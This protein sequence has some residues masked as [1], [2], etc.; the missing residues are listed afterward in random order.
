MWRCSVLLLLMIGWALPSEL[1][2]Q[3][4]A[5]E[6]VVRRAET[7][8]ALSGIQISL[9]GTGRGAISTAVGRFVLRDL[10]PGRYTVVANA[11]GYATERR[12]VRVETGQTLQLAVELAQRA[13]EVGGIT[14]IGQR[15]G[16]VADE[17]VTSKIPAPLIE[18]PQAISVVTRERLEIRNANSLAEAARYAPGIQAEPFGVEPRFTWL[19]LRGFDATTTGLYRDGLQLRNP[20]YAVSFNLEPYGAEQIEVLR[21]PASVLYG[22]GS[23]GGLVN[24]VTKRPSAVP[25]REVE[26]EIGSNERLQGQ[27]DLGGPVN[28]A[29]T[30]SYRLTGLLRDSETQVE[31]VGDDRVF[32]APAFGWRPGGATTLTLLG[33]YQ[34]DETRASQA[35][36]AEG[37][38]TENPFGEVPLD[39]FTGEPDVDRYEATTFSA[40]YLFEHDATDALSLRQKLRFYGAELDDVTVFASA[41]QP[42]A[43]T[44][45]RFLFESF[46]EM[47]G[48]AIDNQAQLELRTGPL[49]HTLLGGLDFQRLDVSSLQTFGAAPPLDVFDPVYGAPVADA[50]VF[51]DDLTDQRQTGFYLQD[52]IEVGERWVLSLAGRY[53]WASTATE[54]R[55]S[56]ASTEQ[57]DEAFTGRA[58]LLYRSPIGLAPY[59]SYSES[60]LPALGTDAE[61][62]PFEPELGRQYEVGLKYQPPGQSSFVTV[63]LFDLARENFLQFDPATFLQVQTGEVVSRGIELEGVSSFPSGVDVVASV[64][65]LDQ[66]ITRSI[67]PAEIGERLTQTPELTASLWAD[68]TLPQG[69]LSGLGVG[70]GV[71][72]IGSSYGDIPN[73]VEVPAV[74]LLDAALFY[75]WKRFRFMLNAQNVLDERHVA[76]AFVRGTPLATF[77]AERTLTAR[78]RYRW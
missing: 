48:L 61:G 64:T 57:D 51:R 72:H 17:A 47:D 69:G 13:V 49:S 34:D 60:F 1:A 33:Y 45:D 35:L 3:S 18:T 67:V 71:R 50:P 77:G 30:V 11:I 15:G 25:I 59:A 62:K 32:I 5:I 29:S 37:L 14:V 55:L 23:P 22:A 21:G 42:D 44:L 31:F 38:L 9:E 40:G 73:T 2:A 74:T 56:N 10:P 58:G 26:L 8:E 46:G 28:E 52:H 43:R 4:G 16:F 75:D 53:D 76:S 70:A 63:A 20:N 24:Y 54:N 27:F 66:E 39:R 65:W 7:G 36:P 19:R 12:Q 41:L 78:L 68:Y 6:G